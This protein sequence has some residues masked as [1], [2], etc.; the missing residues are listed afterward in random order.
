MALPVLFTAVVLGLTSLGLLLLGVS[1][2][3]ILTSAHLGTAA[4]LTAMI[5][6]SIEWPPGWR[7]LNWPYAALILA[8]GVVLHGTDVPA[9]LA[10]ALGVPSGALLLH[11]LWLHKSIV[12]G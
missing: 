6:Y 7:R 8:I 5:G 3:T 10:I 4:G 9:I 11:V 12:S 1:G 2:D